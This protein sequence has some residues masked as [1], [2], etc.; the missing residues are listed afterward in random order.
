MSMEIYLL[1]N[2]AVP[3]TQAW[4]EAIDALGFDVRFVDTQSLQGNEIR[5]RAE[6]QGEPVLME[7]AETSL[8][9]LRETFPKVVFPDGVVLV[10][11]LYWNKTL[12]GGLAAYE[13]AAAYIG[14][15]KGLMIDTEE[16][17]INTPPRAIEIARDMSAR[18]PELKK[19][20]SK[21]I[22]RS[23]N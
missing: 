5:L 7:L 17:K 8:A 11:A 3:T 4:Q 1:T 23:A 21:F 16:G 15:M 19:L 6:C 22:A 12:E 14:L 20:F 13:A 18:M 10:H 2:E 9:R